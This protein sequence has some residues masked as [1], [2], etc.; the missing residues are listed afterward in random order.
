MHAARS[1]PQLQ[2]G[3]PAEHEQRLTDGAGGSV[4]EHALAA[5]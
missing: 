2:T 4:H 5:Q 3:Q 1:A